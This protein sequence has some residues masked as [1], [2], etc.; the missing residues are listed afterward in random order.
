MKPLLVTAFKMKLLVGLND[1]GFIT[2]N[3]VKFKNSS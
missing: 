3:N 2:G 1:G